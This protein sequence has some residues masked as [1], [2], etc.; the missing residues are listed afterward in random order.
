M[1]LSKAL[2]SKPR[3]IAEKLVEE[4][5]PALGDMFEVPE[6]AGPGFLNLRFKPD[7][8]G[9]RISLMLKDAERLSIPKVETPQNV[10]VDFS[11]PNIAKEMHVGHLRS[12]II[13][14]AISRVLELLF[15]RPFLLRSLDFIRRRP[16][17]LLRLV[18]TGIVDAVH[19]LDGTVGI[20]S[21]EL[22]LPGAPGK[23][24]WRG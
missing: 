20:L 8:V 4:L 9:R 13:G 24:L 18:H 16:H 3:D 21:D 12:T 22:L 11:S 1:P 5:K 17:R 14:D 19:R 23:S 6:I 2:K 10:I 15:A 7:Y